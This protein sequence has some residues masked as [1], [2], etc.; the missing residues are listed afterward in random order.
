MQ[1]W[2]G[3]RCVGTPSCPSPLVVSGDACEKPACP[4]GQ[5]RM[6]DGVNCCW[7]QQAWSSSRGV[8]LGTP[9]CP[10]GFSPEGDDCVSEA[11]RRAEE[12]A[13]RRAE[14][15]AARRAEEEAARRAE[16]EAAR[17]D[18]AESPSL[19]LSAFSQPDLSAPYRQM[20]REKRHETM[21]MAKDLLSSGR[22]QG[23]T[24]A[25]MMLRLADLYFEEGR[26]LRLDEAGGDHAASEQWMAR[27]IK[28]YKQILDEYPAFSRADD[29]TYYLGLALWDSGQREVAAEAFARLVKAGPESE[30]VPDAYLMLGEHYFESN[31][32]YN[33]LVAYMKA[34]AYRDGPKYPFAMYKLAWCYRNVGDFGKAIDTMKAALEQAAPGDARLQQAAEADLRRFFAESGEDAEGER[35]FRDRDAPPRRR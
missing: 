20:A 11:A 26:D 27:A 28:L 23:N 18:A 7:P 16:E 21:E 35:Y 3:S 34:A 10:A 6:A 15:E 8:C 25:E 32:A 1:A 12:E 17:R 9:A 22:L 4:E 5:A 19:T 2:N 31:N 30:W 13:A 33:A 24:M 14:E 29:A